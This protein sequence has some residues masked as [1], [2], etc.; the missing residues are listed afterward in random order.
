MWNLK[1]VFSV[2]YIEINLCGCVSQT[3]WGDFFLL[4]CSSD[5]QPAVA[6]KI[7]SDYGPPANVVAAELGLMILS[8]LS[9][10]GVPVY[11][12]PEWQPGD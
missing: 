5:V 11:L 10:K 3:H 1:I 6:S 9:D 4:I 7:R 12:H 2:E 8:S